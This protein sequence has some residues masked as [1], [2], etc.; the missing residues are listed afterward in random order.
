MHVLSQVTQPEKLVEA[1][2]DSLRERAC[3]LDA[4]G[5]IVIT[6]ELW[7]RFAHESGSSTSRSGVGVNYLRICRI[8]VGPFAEG[9]LEAASGIER[10]LRGDVPQFSMDYRCPAPGWPAWFRL[11]ARALGH[12]HT[13]ALILHSDI[14]PQVKLAEKLRITQAHFGALLENPVDVA[15]LLETDGKVRFQSPASES[16][17][18][19]EVKE[20]TG[21]S[22]FEFVHPQDA[23][24]IRRIVR[25][26]IRYPGRKHFCEY[27]LRSSDGSWR[28]LEGIARKLRSDPAGGIMLNSRDITHRKV[29]EQDLL[30]KHDAMTRQRDDLEAL[31]SRMFR[32]REEERR[33]MAAQLNGK[34]SQRLAS[35]SLQ[36]AYMPL[37]PAAAAQ[38]HVLQESVAS[39]GHD[40]YSLGAALYPAMLDHFGLAVALRDYCS[41]FSRTHGIPVSF[42]HRG[43]PGRLA[44]KIGPALYRVAEEALANV[45]K[46][47]HAK[48]A[49]VT[50]SRTVKG[51]RLSVRDDG[52]G[53]NPAT[54]E[55]RTDLGMLAMRERLRGFKGA[56]LSV[57]S[58]LGGGTE[59]VALV[60]LLSAGD[61]PG[62]TVPG[63]VVIDPLNQHEQPVVEFD[64][65]HQVDE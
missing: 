24:A 11:S 35:M 30:A 65:I 25:D 43:I 64:Q 16:V 49:R 26:A 9:A 6:N 14:T 12:L 2:F 4:Q 21:R 54:V 46:H 62:A 18:G 7:D 23:P 38:S 15:T 34:L 17:L 8:A 42:T 20:L 60:P 28:M 58:R 47:S 32:E 37:G 55:P 51:I 63:N 3:V 48:Q 44:G 59:I 1:A 57:H 39:L 31:V 29:A 50:L 52:T 56:S 19:I 40:L 53:F 61:Q 36:A 10:V 33:A 45:A 41:E 5:T 13:G 22:I 27:R